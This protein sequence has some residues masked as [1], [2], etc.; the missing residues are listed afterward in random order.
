MNWQMRAHRNLVQDDALE[1]VDGV[2]GEN[3]AKRTQLGARALG[4]SAR[5]QPQYHMR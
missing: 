1:C 2:H 5:F 4:T 3:T